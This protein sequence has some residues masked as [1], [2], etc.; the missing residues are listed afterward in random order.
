MA[1]IHLGFFGDIN[2]LCSRDSVIFSYPARNR[3]KGG[4]SSD[5]VGRVSSRVLPGADWPLSRD[6]WVS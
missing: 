5:L 6:Y 4:G 2:R 1:T 3:L